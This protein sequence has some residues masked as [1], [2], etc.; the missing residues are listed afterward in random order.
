MIHL[1]NDAEIL[2]Q[3]GTLLFDPLLLNFPGKIRNFLIQQAE[4]ESG[5]TKITIEKAL[6]I[7]NEYMDDLKSTGVIPELHPSQAQRDVHR[8][9][10]S[11]LMSES[12]KEAKKKSVL[13]SVTSKSVLL[14]GRKSINY[15]Y[16][17]DGKS[18]RV[19]IPLHSH[20]TEMKFP[21]YEIIDPFDLDY[22]LRLFRAEKIKA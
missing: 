21:R 6:K 17:T 11:R 4:S 13:L 8:R 5:K 19:E 14:Y 2:Q 7:F 20:G 16:G 12:F 1:T 3:L 18:N 9:H 10:F 15:I 22:M